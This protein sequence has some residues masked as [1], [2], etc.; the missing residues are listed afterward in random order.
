MRSRRFSLT[1][2]SVTASPQTERAARAAG[3]QVAS[4]ANVGALDLALD[5]A[6]QVDET[7]W[8][9]KGGGAHTR[10]KLLAAAAQRFAVLVS[11]DKLVTRA[12]PPVPLELV[13]HRATATLERLE[14]ARLREDTPP[15]PDGG[16]IADY[17]GGF[18]DPRMLS[19]RLDADPGVVA[20]GLFAPETVHCVLVAN[21]WHVTAR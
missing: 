7:R 11:S 10:E 3:L 21:G 13:P 9:I 12:R 14:D 4:F 19:H 16:L 1:S 17:V 8:L 6:D 20:H 2:C 5:G 15:S 18:R